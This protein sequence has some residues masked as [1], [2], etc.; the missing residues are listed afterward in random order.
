MKEIF[1]IMKCQYKRNSIKIE[2]NVDYD[3]RRFFSIQDST[4]LNSQF[5]IVCGKMFY[6][7]IPFNTSLHFAI[8]ERMK[9]IIEKNNICGSNFFSIQ[10]ENSITVWGILP[11]SNAGKI[12]NL[13]RL[14][15]L[16]D[17][18]IEFEL[19]SWNGSDIFCLKDSLC[20]VCTSKVKKLLESH[21]FTNISFELCFGI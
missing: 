18:S 7:V 16:E 11:T 1:F 9:N 17:S 5:K 14:N 19:S 2:S 8:S 20:L 3:F 15:N 21:K 13:E 10:L 4:I 6:D 12:V